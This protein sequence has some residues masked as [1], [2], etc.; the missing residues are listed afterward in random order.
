MLVVILATYFAICWKAGQNVREMYISIVL[1]T[2]G[3]SDQE[4]RRGLLSVDPG[5]RKSPLDPSSVKTLMP[6]TANQQVTNGIRS[7][8]FLMEK[9][10]TRGETP[11]NDS[12]VGTSETTRENPQTETTR[13]FNQ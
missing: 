5:S 11:R 2:R 3:V 12:L 6:V 13:K 1:S 7:S 4:R 9:E 10:E 8:L